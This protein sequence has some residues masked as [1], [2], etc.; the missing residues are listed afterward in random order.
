MLPE[1]KGLVYGYS[2]ALR[3]LAVGRT[4]ATRLVQ[5]YIGLGEGALFGGESMSTIPRP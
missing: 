4:V 2:S 5:R 1:Y 3:T